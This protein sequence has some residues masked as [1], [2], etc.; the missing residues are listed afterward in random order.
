VTVSLTGGVRHPKIY[1][2]TIEQFKST[3]WVGKRH[4]AGLLKVGDTQRDVRI[5][6]RE[7]LAAITMPIETVPEVLLVEAAITDDGRVFR[8]HEVHAALKKAGYHNVAGE[9]YECTKD[10]VAAAIQAV[11]EGQ[12]LPSSLLAANFPMRPEQARAVEQ[13]A[14]YLRAN[15]KK[16]GRAPDY[17]WNA[18]M[19][20]GKTFTTYQLAKEMGWTRV[21]V[22]TYK[23]AVEQ[24]WREDLRHEDFAGW[25][26]YGKADSLPD[27]KNPSPLIWFASFQD[28]LG[29][30]RRRRSRRSRTATSTRS[31]GTQSWSMSTTLAPGV[32]PRVP[33]TV[34]EI[35]EVRL[36]RR[37]KVIKHRSQGCRHSGPG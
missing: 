20:F 37:P 35:D 23:P 27:I 4:G 21:L 1:A 26:F 22:L 7:Q 3:P 29:K 24:N 30:G 9:W 12:D 18:K 28:V 17:L 31:S 15:S 2:Y 25:R 32:M 8:D 13:T 14:T 11:R 5:R 10:E 19:R 6:I 34:G 33:Y 36:A 16:K